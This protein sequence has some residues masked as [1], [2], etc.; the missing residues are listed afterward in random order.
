VDASLISFFH[1][2]EST[3]D[4]RTESWVEGRKNHD[5]MDCEFESPPNFGD[6]SCDVG[7]SD[8]CNTNT[9]SLTMNFDSCSTNDPELSENLFFMG[10]QYFVVQE[11]E[12]VESSRSQ[13][14]QYFQ[15][16]SLWLGIRNCENYE[17]ENE[18][19]KPLNL[20]DDLISVDEKSQHQKRVQ[21][22]NNK[23]F[24]SSRVAGRDIFDHRSLQLTYEH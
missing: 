5:T 6:F 18:K 19:T 1:I 7:G 15:A 14:Q 10:W 9:K 2:E 13:T 23:T 17:R 22:F 4:S 24:T 16:N 21:R 20:G 8:N 12:V 3:G 11:I